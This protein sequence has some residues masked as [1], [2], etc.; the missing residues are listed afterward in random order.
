MIDFPVGRGHARGYLAVPEGGDVPGVLVLHAWWGLN[1]FFKKFCDRLADNG[2]VALAPD[3][4][5]GKV[6]STIDEAMKLR[7]KLRRGVVEK[8]LNGAVNYLR[9]TVATNEGRIGVVGF[10]IGAN[11]G[12]RLATLRSKDVTAVVAF[13]GG[14]IENYKKARVA[15][16]GH[17]AEK[18]E[19]E[20]LD[21][22][23]KLEKSIRSA[24]SETTFYVYPNAK[25][26]FFEENRPSQY[27]ARA[28]GL[29][30]RR[31]VRFLHTHLNGQ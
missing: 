1:P 23:Q 12:L 15:F 8:Q 4:H 9:K 25:H 13:Y 17:F 27:D 24:G 30:W 20:P 5:H 2:F 21:E 16:L 31:T 29:A 14:R 22:V 28:A 18:D 3:L 7:S 19:W 10:S 26:W 6:A 11:F